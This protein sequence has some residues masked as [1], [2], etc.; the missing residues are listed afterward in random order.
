M[1]RQETGIP[2]THKQNYEHTWKME[3]VC[4][5]PYADTHIPH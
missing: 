1:L 3:A 5:L 2:H 4:F